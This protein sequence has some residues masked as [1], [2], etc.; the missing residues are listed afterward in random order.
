MK[1]KVHPSPQ[2][3]PGC[4]KCWSQRCLDVLHPRSDERWREAS[5]EATPSPFW[6]RGSELGLAPTELRG[7][8]RRDGEREGPLSGYKGVAGAA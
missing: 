8:C 2:S 4:A 3:S 7:R 1:L 6:P 5:A